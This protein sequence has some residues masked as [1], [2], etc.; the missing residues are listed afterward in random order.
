MSRLTV[1]KQNLHERSFNKFLFFA[2]GAN[3]NVVAMAKILRCCGSRKCLYKLQNV[4]DLREGEA[5]RLHLLKLIWILA[6]DIVQH[7]P[8]KIL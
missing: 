8:E 4:E 2:G 6:E 3:L 5:S 7:K 1:K